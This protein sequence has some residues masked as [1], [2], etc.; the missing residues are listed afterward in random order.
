MPQ[1]AS[2][3]PEKL[4]KGLGHTRKLSH[5]CAESAYYVKIMIVLY[6]ITW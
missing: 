3:P 1:I 4:G 5:I 6:V 2:P